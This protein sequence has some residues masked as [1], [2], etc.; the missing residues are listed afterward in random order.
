MKTTIE[1]K[2]QNR[3]NAINANAKVRAANESLKPANIAKGAAIGTLKDITI[4][5]GAVGEMVGRGAKRIMTSTGSM[6][7]RM[8]DK[9]KADYMK[10]E[11]RYMMPE[12][13]K[14]P[15]VEDEIKRTGG[16]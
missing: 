12:E 10:G 14:N 4:G 7:R 2:M 13:M 11:K 6:V 3:V 1:Q 9:R 5:R 8:M 15:K 16:I